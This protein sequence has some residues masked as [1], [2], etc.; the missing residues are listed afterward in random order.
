MTQAGIRL[1]APAKINLFLAVKGLRAD[2][3]HDLATVMHQVSLCDV[4][5]IKIDEKPGIRL[6]TTNPELADDEG[7]LAY[8]AAAL[9]MKKAG[10]EQGVDIFIEKHIPLGAGLAGGSADAAAVIKGLNLIMGAPFNDKDLLAIAEML[11]SDVPFCLYGGTVLAW[12]R[13]ELLSPIAAAG[14]PH[15]VLV[16]PPFSLSTAD[17]YSTWDKRGERCYPPVTDMVEALG[18]GDWRKVGASLYNSLETVAAGQHHEIPEIKARLLSLGAEGALMSGSGPTVFGVFRGY[19]DAKQAY[20][21]LLRD[22]TE[23]FL[24][25]SYRPEGRE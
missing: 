4:V 23:C 21:E 18:R 14:E 6:I 16:K 11:G 24:V 22:Y 13:G 25:S 20:L 3:Y 15:F 10:L 17:V 5:Q 7:N 19:T 12:G 8:R 2:G 1:L 9:F